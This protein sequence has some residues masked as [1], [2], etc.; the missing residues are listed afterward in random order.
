MLRNGEQLHHY[1]VIGAK[2]SGSYGHV[3]EVQ[4]INTNTAVALKVLSGTNPDNDARFRA[5]NS[6]LHTLIKSLFVIDPKTK[7]IDFSG[8]TFYCMELA[9][10]NTE[11]YLSSNQ[12]S[13]EAT[14][15]LFKEICNGLKHAHDNGIVHRDLHLKNVLL[16]IDSSNN[17]SPRLTD[18]GMAKNFNDISLSSMPLSVWGAVLFRSPEIFFM[19]WDTAELE[20]YILADIYS[21]G[22]I[23]HILFEARPIAYITGLVGSINNYLWHQGVATNQSTFQI[24]PN[25]NS[26]LKKRYYE[27]WLKKYDYS[28]QDKLRIILRSPNPSLEQEINRIIQKCCT[29][30]YNKRYANIGELLKDI[31]AIC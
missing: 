11:S 17:I 24:D 7:V 3:F 12:L 15:K 29:P 21:L 16:M 10:T 4:D 14:L 8:K 6:H 19:A 22:I 13:N 18:F 26:A 31:E 23:L 9:N 27:D 2:G 30:D 20:K 25:V 1:V 5:E 28:N